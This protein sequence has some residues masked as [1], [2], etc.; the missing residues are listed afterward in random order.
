MADALRCGLYQLVGQRFRYFGGKE[1]G[2]GICELIDLRMHRG[3]HVRMPMPQ[4]GYRCA[5]GSIDISPALGIG[6]VH[7]C[8]LTATGGVCWRCRCNTWVD[9]VDISLFSSLKNSIRRLA[10]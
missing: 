9:I 1:T 2:V 5:A 4:A 10:L 3:Q 6:Q 7:P 8:P